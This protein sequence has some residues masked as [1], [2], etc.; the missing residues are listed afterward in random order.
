MRCEEALREIA[1]RKLLFG[2]DLVKRVVECEESSELIVKLANE[3]DEISDGWFSVHAVFILSIIGNDRAFEA[4]K[5]IATTRDLGDFAIEDLPYLFARLEGKT[6]ELR[7]IAENENFDVF[8]RLAAFK[9]LMHLSREDAKIVAEKLLE[10]VKEK[11]DESCIFLMYISILG[12]KL[13][14][15]CLKLAE[16]C[17]IHTEDLL[18]ELDF[19]LEDP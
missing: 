3:L 13:K 15:K 7:E 19:R 9:A 18:T 16:D 12:G 8:V 6:G 14:E 5:H 4:L 11:K 1:R 2:K 17:K 10:E